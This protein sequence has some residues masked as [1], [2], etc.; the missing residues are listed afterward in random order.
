L[1][2]AARIL[3][4]NGFEQ[5]AR[6]L[7]NSYE[8][9]PFSVDPSQGYHVENI[10]RLDH[11]FRG[12][13]YVLL[14]SPTERGH[15]FEVY[16]PQHYGM[17]N[18]GISKKPF[19]K[20]EVSVLYSNRNRPDFT[21]VEGITLEFFRFEDIVFDT[22]SPSLEDMIHNYIED[23]TSFRKSAGLVY[24]AVIKVHT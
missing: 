18:V 12:I 13:Q 3:K 17:I 20:K 23:L 14:F 1:A 2:Y 10:T 24:D 8:S 9:S 11:R 4:E 19:T 5:H 21:T 22:M 6:K 7:I 15:I 16:L